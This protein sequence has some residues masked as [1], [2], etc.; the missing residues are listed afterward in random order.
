[1]AA[2]TTCDYCCK[3]EG[4]PETRGWLIV[5]QRADDTW[6]DFCSWRCLSEY[7][8]VHADDADADAVTASRLRRWLGQAR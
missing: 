3:T 5:V 1:M 6:R 7:A 2:T 4:S 8:G